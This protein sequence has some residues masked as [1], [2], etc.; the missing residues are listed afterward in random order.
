M[1]AA[2]TYPNQYLLISEPPS[3]VAGSPHKMLYDLIKTH[4]I[5]VFHADKMVFAYL[6]GAVPNAGGYSVEDAVVTLC[7]REKLISVQLGEELANGIK[8]GR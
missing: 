2:R 6:N 5:D 3:T 4:K 1:R 7:V 8:E